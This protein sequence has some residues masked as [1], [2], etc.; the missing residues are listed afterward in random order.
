MVIGLE[1]DQQLVILLVFL[2]KQSSN[3][4]QKKE[5]QLLS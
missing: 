4:I 1:I 5:D 3:K 2:S